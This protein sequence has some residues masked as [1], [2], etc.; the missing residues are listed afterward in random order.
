VVETQES[1]EFQP[2]L[3]AS[4]T[5]GFTAVLLTL[6]YE[7]GKFHISRRQS[8]TLYIVVV[9][10]SVAGYPKEFAHDADRI[11]L[12]AAIDCF[13]FCGSFRFLPAA[14]RK[15][16][17]NSFS[18]LGRL[19]SYLHSCNVRPAYAPSYFT[20]RFSCRP[21]CQY[22]RFKRLDIHPTSFHKNCLPLQLHYPTMG[23]NFAM[24]VFIG[25]VQATL[26]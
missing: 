19:F 26:A 13:M 20:P 8:T 25:S 9:V 6:G 11:F 15:S 1:S 4:A 24:S 16:R 7:N 5:I 23:G 3:N 10:I 17:S 12:T 14:R 18:I 2:N 22:L 21:H